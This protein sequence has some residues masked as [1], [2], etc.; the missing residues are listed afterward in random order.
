MQR[1]RR[2]K[3]SRIP[4][5]DADVQPF[6]TAQTHC[7]CG[8]IRLLFKEEGCIVSHATLSRFPGTAP[9]P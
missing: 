3:K 1:M 2:K 8:A 7:A 5:K 9:I 6:S 4:E